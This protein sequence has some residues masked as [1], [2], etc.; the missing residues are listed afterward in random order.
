MYECVV[1][2]VELMSDLVTVR[3]WF[4]CVCVCVRERER[5]RESHLVTVYFV[6]CVYECASALFYHC[7]CVVCVCVSDNNLPSA[8]I[9]F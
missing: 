7:A 2:V 9:T 3:V 5:E 1:R 4:V 6:L 8:S